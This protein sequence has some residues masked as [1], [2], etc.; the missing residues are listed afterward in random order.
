MS[1]KNLF[2]HFEK[3]HISTARA[4]EQQRATDSP[5]LPATE[6]RSPPPHRALVAP[7]KINKWYVLSLSIAII[8][9]LLFFFSLPLLGFKHFSLGLINVKSPSAEPVLRESDGP[10]P[11][12]APLKPGN[13]RDPLTKITSMDSREKTT[14]PGILISLHSRAISLNPNEPQAWFRLMR[15]FDQNGLE[16]KADSIAMAIESR[17]GADI[18]AIQQCIDPY[19]TVQS[20]SSTGNVCR[21]RYL[22]IP[23]NKDL[24]LD[25]S[26]QICRALAVRRLCSS[27]SLFAATAKGSGLLVFIRMSRMPASFEEF[28]T[29][30]TISYTE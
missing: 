28:K 14:A 25:Q 20:F 2:K 17:F 30:A 24:L 1:P 8:A 12:P 15:V 19:G 26:Y 3:E 11:E 10:N 18:L 6:E 22:S 13:R 4:S 29:N 7:G 5:G 9:Y 27:I 23:R 16:S 21:I